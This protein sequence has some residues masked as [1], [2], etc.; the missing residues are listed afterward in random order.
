MKVPGVDFTKSFS[1]VASDTPTRVR[2]G[3]TLYYEEDGCIGEL[4]DK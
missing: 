1:P 3:L 4:C 2:I